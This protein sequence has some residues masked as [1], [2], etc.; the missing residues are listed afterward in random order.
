MQ[1]VELFHIPVE[2]QLGL[3][4]LI[5]ICCLDV[6]GR[7]MGLK[8][9]KDLVTRVLHTKESAKLRVHDRTFLTRAN[10]FGAGV[11]IDRKGAIAHIFEDDDEDATPQRKD[12]FFAILQETTSLGFPLLKTMLLKFPKDEEHNR[13]FL[14]FPESNSLKENIF[15]SLKMIQNK[16]DFFREV[17]AI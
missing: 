17:E 16:P 6:Y 12:V 8:E 15:F 3:I 13:V 7:E 11:R 2:N 1:V 14:F 9:C 10:E 4:K 5:R